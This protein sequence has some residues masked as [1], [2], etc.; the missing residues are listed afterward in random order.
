[1]RSTWRYSGILTSFI[2]ERYGVILVLCWE[3]GCYC[4]QIN[5]Q[6][7]LRKI[8]VSLFTLVDYRKLQTILAKTRLP[9]RRNIVCCRDK[10]SLEASSANSMGQDQ[11]NP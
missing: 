10:I 1:M 11:T 5:V 4:Q 7:S 6:M 3:T 9:T 2:L 8:G